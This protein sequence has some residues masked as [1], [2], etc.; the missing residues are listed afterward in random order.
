M[1]ARWIRIC[2]L[3]LRALL[4]KEDLDSELA[5]EFAFHFDQLVQQNIEAG[6]A[7]YKARR[8]AHIALGNTGILAEQCRDHRRVGW[9]HDLWQ[10]IRYGLRMLWKSP[11]FTTTAAFSL[12]LGI[13]ANVAIIYQIVAI[14]HGALPYASPEQLVLIRTYPREDPS[15]LSQTS[16][17][18]YYV[19]KERSRSFESMGVS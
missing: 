1:L 11:G 13:G 9:A 10:D 2:R 7:P 16:L 14:Q 12:S 3:R 8:S 18:D 5:Q 19:L 15:Q 17:A 4:R 6:M